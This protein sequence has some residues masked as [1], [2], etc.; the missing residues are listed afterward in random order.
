MFF[1]AQKFRDF[2]LDSDPMIKGDI[3]ICFRPTDTFNVQFQQ[4][5]AKVIGVIAFTEEGKEELAYTHTQ[6][7]FHIIRLRLIIFHTPKFF[8]GDFTL[9]FFL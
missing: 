4:I 7:V 5:A 8:N 3:I 1:G 9:I 6:C 2:M